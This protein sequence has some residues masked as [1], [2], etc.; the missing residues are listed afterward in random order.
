[1]ATFAYLRVSTH[2]QTVENQRMEIM[3]G[4]FTPDYFFCDEGVS[5]SSAAAQR[6]QFR[7]LLDRIRPGETLV[8]TKLDR[9]GRDAHDVGATLKGLAGRGISVIVI[10]LGRL[11]LTSPAGRM[12]LTMLGAVAEMERDLLIERTRAGLDRARSQGKTLGRPAKIAPEGRRALIEMR[13]AGA[14]ISALARR[15]TVSRATIS[16]IVEVEA[17]TAQAGQ[18]THD[19]HAPSTPAKPRTRTRKGA[20]GRAGDDMADRAT[21]E[22]KHGQRRLP[23]V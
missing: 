8:V 10:Q 3:K 1:M 15:F 6:P 14:S 22:Q 18:T 9:L 17:G 7:L 2:E 23:A 21:L 20:A 19:S 5:G 4:G 12:M 16:R 11:D 13:Q